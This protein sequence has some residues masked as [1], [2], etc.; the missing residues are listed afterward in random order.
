MSKQ[1]TLSIRSLNQNPLDPFKPLKKVLNLSSQYTKSESKF[2]QASRWLCAAH[3][4]TRSTKLNARL[5]S[6]NTAS[7]FST[8]RKSL[9]KSCQWGLVSEKIKL[10]VWNYWQLAT[11]SKSWLGFTNWDSTWKSS[12]RSW[13]KRVPL[14]NVLIKQDQSPSVQVFPGSKT[15]P[16]Q[17]A[18][19][20]SME[21]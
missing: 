20:S 21:L 1:W 9:L 2:L 12:Q 7:P 3:V 16:N 5:K 6:T 4:M 17:C 15:S 18:E 19:L 11:R 13:G 8:M 10:L 14:T